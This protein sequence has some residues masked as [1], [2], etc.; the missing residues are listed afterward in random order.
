[1]QNVKVM[2]PVQAKGPEFGL[3]EWPIDKEEQGYMYT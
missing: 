3:Q 1:M 2:V